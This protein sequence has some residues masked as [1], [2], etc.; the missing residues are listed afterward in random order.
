M[1]P[2]RLVSSA[3]FALACLAGTATALAQFP[4]KPIKLI[5]GFPPGGGSD[6]AARLRSSPTLRG[7]STPTASARTCGIRA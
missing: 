5:V 2:A 1:S 7:A 4:N 6:A 3:F